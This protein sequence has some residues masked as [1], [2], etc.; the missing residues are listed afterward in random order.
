MHDSYLFLRVLPCS[1]RTTLLAGAATTAAQQD[2]ESE[3]QELG[4]GHGEPGAT[5]AED[6][7]QQEVA[8]DEERKAAEEDEERG[9]PHLLD[10]LVVADDGDIDDEADDT[11]GEVGEA[12]DSNLAGA[13]LRV[14]EERH[15]PARHEDEEERHDDAEARS[16]TEKQ[17]ARAGHLVPALKAVVERDDGLR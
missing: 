11:R 1:P 7:G 5:D 12:A 8:R 14:D 4:G 3:R 13:A 16:R 2:A 6:G 10:A 15:E 9:A 17:A